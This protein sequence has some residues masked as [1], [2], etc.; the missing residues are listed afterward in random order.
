MLIINQPHRTTKQN[1]FFTMC[2]HSS[3]L[4]FTNIF[5]NLFS[6]LITLV[7]AGSIKFS[8]AVIEGDLR[9]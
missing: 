3:R 1:H 2:A 7:I 9:V 4:A 8:A 5:H 6:H